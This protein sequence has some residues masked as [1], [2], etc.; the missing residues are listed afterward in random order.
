MA[1]YSP[2]PKPP[3]IDR[4]WPDRRIERAPIWCSVDLRDGNQALVE[5]MGVD[6]KLAYFDLLV[7]MGFKEI[8][9]GF[10]S[11]SQIEFDFAR[12]LIENDRIPAGVAIQV[13][14]QCREHLVARTFESLAGAKKA[15]FHIYNSTSPV[16]RKVTFGL[17]K[18]EIKAIAIEGARLVKAGLGSV[19][20][21]D[22]VLEYSPESFSN[23]EVEYA[24]EVCEAVMHE[25]GPTPERPIILNLPATV[26][27]STPNLYA[28]MIEWFVTHL[29]RRDCAIVSLHTHNDRGTGVAASELGLLAGADRIEGTLFGNGERTG[30]LDIVNMA[31]NLFSEGMD[32]GLDL[33]NIPKLAA[34][35][36]DFTGMEI[37]M[38]HPYAGDLVYTAFS[39]SHQDAI[40]KGIEKRGPSAAPGSPWEVPYLPIDPRDIGRSYE[41]IIRINSQSGKGGV[42]YILKD[43][44]GYD[45]P[46]AMHPEVG[47]FVNR[48]AD[49]RGKE[50]D[51]ESI[52]ALFEGEFM[53]VSEPIAL[54]SFN[55]VPDHVNGETTWK[56]I[57]RYK[58]EQRELVGKGKG[59]ID[60]FVKSLAGLG[61]EDIGVVSFH[62]DALTTGADANAVAYIQA[63]VPGIPS[64]WG[65]GLDPSIAA[66]GVRAVLSAVN[67]SLAKART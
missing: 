55:E 24:L 8:E 42:A 44:A 53:N 48:V 1:K 38:R 23:T 17:G 2:F 31:L 34:A 19:L 12:A 67:R 49:V 5:P 29:S 35:Y 14:C 22:I 61:I 50:V 16:Q 25:W 11:A 52:R 62:E 39:G 47:L 51:A 32:P 20:G 15:I 10:P 18:D 43:D 54:L 56:S 46:K 33:L 13:L 9:I 65:A 59:P 27:S 3:A 45:L 21:T 37:P 28:D 6:E 7:Q 30:N 63:R 26:E 58:G 64:T 66:A 4:R 36:T 40:K 41:A 57:V 60:A